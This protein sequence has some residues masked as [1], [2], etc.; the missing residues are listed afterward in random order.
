M[1]SM[2]SYLTTFIV[3]V[4]TALLIFVIRLF[5]KNSMESTKKW[6]YQRQLL[7]A[8]IALLGFFLAIGFLPLDHQV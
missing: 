4:G 3:I 5:F 7:T 2:L 8:G 1:E 6:P